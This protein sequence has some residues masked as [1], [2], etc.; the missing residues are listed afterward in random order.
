MENKTLAHFCFEEIQ[1]RI[2]QGRL[3]PGS[4]LKVAALA[5]ELQMGPTPVREALSRLADTGLVHAMDNRGF[6]VSPI[7]EQDICDLYETFCKIEVLALREAVEK[8]DQE[9]ESQVIATLYQLGLIEL[10]PQ[11]ASYLIW[12]PYNSAFHEALVR[13]CKSPSLLHV[14]QELFRRFDRYCHLSFLINQDLLS[15][16]HEEHRQIAEAAL[17]RD[18]SKAAQYLSSHILG[19]LDPV[20]AQLKSQKLL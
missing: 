6:R 9:W 12:T 19:G 3:L 11:S 10:N 16:N 8:G 15:F 14:R 17:Q 1:S 5:Q 20:I 7:S 2:I 4:K 13:G 18:A